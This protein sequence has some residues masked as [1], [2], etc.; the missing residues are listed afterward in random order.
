VVGPGERRLSVESLW[1]DLRYA[2]RTIGRNPAFASVAVVSLALGI[3]A[4]TTIFTLINAVFLNP[5]QAERPQELVAVFTI[6]ENNPGQFTNMNPVSFPNFEDYRDQN[7][8]FTDV[9]CY[10]FPF[11]LSVSRLPEG[12]DA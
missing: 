12:R 2:F 6:D 9:V 1:R 3:G 11:P 4:N 8:V 5:I 7:E 10:S